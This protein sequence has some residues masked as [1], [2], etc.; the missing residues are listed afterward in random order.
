VRIFVPHDVVE[1]HPTEE[2]R[3]VLD[4]EH[5]EV[6]HNACT[7]LQAGTAVVLV[8]LCRQDLE[9]LTE[10]FLMQLDSGVAWVDRAG[11]RNAVE[12]LRKEDPNVR[13]GQSHA[14]NQ[15]RTLAAQRILIL[16]S[17]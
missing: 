12:P 1:G 4:G 11:R 13:H 9:Y 8:L 5:A 2:P 15:R 7:G 14:R 10:I 6:A 3:N 16:Y 17:T